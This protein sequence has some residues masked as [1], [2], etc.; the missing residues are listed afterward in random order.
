M[1]WAFLAV[2]VP[3]LESADFTPP[4]CSLAP[5][6]AG[7]WADASLITERLC[8]WACGSLPA[9]SFLSR[10]EGG[11]GRGL[12]GH[13]PDL[14]FLICR[15]GGGVGVLKIFTKQ[16]AIFRMGLVKL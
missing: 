6:E 15:K 10:R 5:G 9:M 2:A 3:A 7:L 8:S 14:P 12:H 16:F 13:F 11:R 4:G 1:P